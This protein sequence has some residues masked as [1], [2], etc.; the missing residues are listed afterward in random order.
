MQH[1]SVI[2]GS[3]DSG[4]N[5][6]LQPQAGHASAVDKGH[7]WNRTGI[8]LAGLGAAL[9]IIGIVGL[10]V[11]AS[12]DI[13]RTLHVTSFASQPVFV[14]L[15]AAS[16]TAGFTMGSAGGLLLCD[17]SPKKQKTRKE[18]EKECVIL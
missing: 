2:A 5:N 18:K 3:G 9:F 4:N 1:L 12:S 14:L 10:T 15:T 16:F 11:V 7:K 13:A 8:A 6:P 17:N